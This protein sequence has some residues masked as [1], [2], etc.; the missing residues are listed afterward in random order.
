M[1]KNDKR[2]SPPTRY[3]PGGKIASK[4]FKA[5]T[6]RRVDDGELSTVWK[7]GFSSLVSN[8]IDLIQS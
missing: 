3:Y 5:A 2:A 8:S 6:N 1:Q 4:E 7:C